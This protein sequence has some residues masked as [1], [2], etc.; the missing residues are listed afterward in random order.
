MQTQFT[1]FEPDFLRLTSETVWCSLTTLDRANRPRSRIIHPIWDIGRDGPVGW[2]PTRRSPIKVA[3][4]AHSPAVSC[5]YWRPS[6]DAVLVQCRA[7]WDDDPAEKSRIWNWFASTPPPLGYDPSTIWSG[8]PDDAEY[9]LLRFDAWRVQIVTVET[10]NTR[11][12]RVWT[13]RC[14]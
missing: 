9:A 5:A 7:V 11:R 8:G 10:L 6:H 13:A 2:L 4:L 3:H 14:D 1:D 12:P